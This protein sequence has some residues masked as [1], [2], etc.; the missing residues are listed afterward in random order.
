MDRARM[1]TYAAKSGDIEPPQLRIAHVFPESVMSCSAPGFSVTTVFRKR[2]ARISVD[3][4][5]AIAAPIAS[6]RSC[7]A[8][9]C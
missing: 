9:T 4:P 8:V 1:K 3:T 2:H 7:R 5:P 6:C